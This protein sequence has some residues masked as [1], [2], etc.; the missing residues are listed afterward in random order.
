[1]KDKYQHTDPS[2]FEKIVRE[3]LGNHHL[4][5]DDDCWKEIESRLERKTNRKAL[6]WVWTSLGTAA[7][8]ALLFTIGSHFQ[9]NNIFQSD[10]Q[11]VSHGSSA[12]AFGR[13]GD[14]QC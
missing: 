14:K 3:K 5:V 13:S 10:Q 4:P 2:E 1:M 9:Q 12:P 7:V 6:W 11:P 8:I